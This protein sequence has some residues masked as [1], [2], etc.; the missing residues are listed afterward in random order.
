[1]PQFYLLRLLGFG[2]D[3][4]AAAGLRLLPEERDSRGFVSRDL[5]LESRLLLSRLGDGT[6]PAR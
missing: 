6:V 5:R 2:E 1:M 3:E 4:A